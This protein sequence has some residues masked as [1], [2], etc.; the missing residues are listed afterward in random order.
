MA[1]EFLSTPT[2]QRFYF[3]Q[4]P[5]LRIVTDGVTAT[6][7]SLTSATVAFVASDVGASVTGAGIQAGTTISTVTNGTT[8][9]LSQA[10][11]ASASGVTVT[12]TKTA[13]FCL[14]TFQT[15]INTDFASYFTTV[16]TLVTQPGAPLVALL[17]VSPAQVISVSPGQYAGYN[18]GTWQVLPASSMTGSLFTPATV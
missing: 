1:T 15:A 9:V 2:I 17:I 6:S 10:T 3:T 18:Y 16:P 13:A 12:I 7:T 14:S 8:V 5:G 4:H 11:T